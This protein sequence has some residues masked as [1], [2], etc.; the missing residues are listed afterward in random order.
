MWEVV[1]TKQADKDKKKLKA[2]GLETKARSLIDVIKAEP[3][4]LCG[5]C[6]LTDVCLPIV[7]RWREIRVPIAPC[8]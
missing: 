4:S 7:L 2:A 8:A 3:L 1:Y 5:V 6:S